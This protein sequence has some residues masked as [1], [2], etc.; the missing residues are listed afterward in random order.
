[1]AADIPT[2]HESALSKFVIPL[3]ATWSI[4]QIN[5][6]IQYYIDRPEVL[7]QMAVD[8]FVYARQHLT[9]TN[10]I[11][12]ILEMADHYREGSR[13]YECQ[14]RW[15]LLPMYKVN[16]FSLVPYGFSMRCRAYWSDENGYRP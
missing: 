7:Q 4:E 15:Y 14:Y 9:I 10:K 5:A 16:L 2:E 6:A 12:H 8:G 3:K 13:G 1:M 11:S